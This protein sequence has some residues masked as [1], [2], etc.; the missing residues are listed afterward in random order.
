[1]DANASTKRVFQGRKLINFR[2]SWVSDQDYETELT[3][4]WRRLAEPYGSFAQRL[5][6]W[7]LNISISIKTIN[8]TRL[9]GPGSQGVQ[10]FAN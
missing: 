2:E 5:V 10:A 4:Q 1:M 7:A 6:R 9:V 3:V 8:L